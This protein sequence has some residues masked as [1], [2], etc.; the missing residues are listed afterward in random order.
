MLSYRSDSSIITLYTQIH[1][2]QPAFTHTDTQQRSPCFQI[3]YIL[4]SEK[5]RE[6]NARQGTY[7]RL[8]YDDCDDGDGGGGGGGGG[9]GN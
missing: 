8:W 5:E 1:S 4:Q 6:E 3:I 9:G 2:R 7:V